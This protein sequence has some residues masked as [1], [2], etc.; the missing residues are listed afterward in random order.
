MAP[1]HYPRLQ[2]GHLLTSPTNEV[3]REGSPVR[4]PAPSVRSSGP[5][6]EPTSGTI[7]PQSPVSHVGTPPPNTQPETPHGDVISQL[8]TVIIQQQASIA[9]LLEALQR[10]MDAVASKIEEVSGANMF[11]WF[12]GLRPPSFS[13]APVSVLAQHWLN[14]MAKMM[15]SLHCSDAQKVILATY[16]LEGEADIWWEGMLRRVPSDYEWTWNE[17][18]KRFNEK[19]FPPFYRHEKISEFLKLEQGNMTV[20]QYEVCFDELSRYVPKAVEDEEYKLEKFK[21][22][23]RLEIQSRLCT[24]DFTDFADLVD[25]AMRI[26]KDFERRSKTRALIQGSASK[27]KTTPIASPMAEKRME[28]VP[29]LTHSSGQDKLCDYCRRQGHFLK[30]CFKK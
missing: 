10:N 13:G 5:E 17:F 2:T 29:H 23:L 20:S 15:R 26:N 11:E 7:P 4:S 8:T 18:K 27:A 19:Y 28:L 24:F 9:T 12:Q 25:K 22:G 16:A 21:I 6:R 14:K 3:V 30:Q 1:S